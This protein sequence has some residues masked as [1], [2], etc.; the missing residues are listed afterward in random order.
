MGQEIITRLNDGSIDSQMLIGLF[1]MGV[2]GLLMMAAAGIAT[3]AMRKRTAAARHLVWMLALCGL[4]LLPVLTAAMPRWTLPLPPNKMPASTESRVLAEPIAIA[5]VAGSERAQYAPKQVSVN[6]ATANEE[7]T[8]PSS[9]ERIVIER[10]A[11]LPTRIAPLVMGLWIGI[12]T[13]SFSC[14]LTGLQA[15]NQLK[16]ASLP[17]E[18]HGFSQLVESLSVTLGLPRTPAVRL[19]P[20]GSMPMATGLFRPIVYLPGDAVNWS[21]TKLRVVL[22]HEL[23]H[24]K[25][26]DC[27]TYA[28]ARAAVALHWYNPLGWFALRQLR[29]EREHACDDLVLEC[30][31]RPS[32]Y[33]EVLLEIAQTMRTPLGIGAAAVTMA[34]KSHV[35]ARLRA[36]LDGTRNRSLLTRRLIVSSA[37]STASLVVLLSTVAFER[38]TIYPPLH[39]LVYTSGIQVE[40]AAVSSAHPEEVKRE[41]WKPDGGALQERLEGFQQHDWPDLKEGNGANRLVGL[42]IKLPFG[43]PGST[44]VEYIHHQLPYAQMTTD[45]ANGGHGELWAFVDA[46][47][48]KSTTDF[49]LGIATGE[50]STIAQATFGEDVE[51]QSSDMKSKS[52]LVGDPVENKGVKRFYLI[53]PA[54]EDRYRVVGVKPDGKTIIFGESAERLLS[55]EHSSRDFFINGFAPEDFSHLALQMRRCEWRTFHGIAVNPVDPIAATRLSEAAVES[56]RKSQTELGR[57]ANYGSAEIRI[58]PAI[59]ARG[60]QVRW[61]STDTDLGIRTLVP[62]RAGLRPQGEPTE[63]PLLDGVLWSDGDIAAL[64]VVQGPVPEEFALQFQLTSEAGVRWAKTTETSI[65]KQLALVLDGEVIY[66]AT[67]NGGIAGGMMLLTDALDQAEAESLVTTIRAA[68]PEISETVKVSSNSAATLGPEV[69]VTVRHSGENCM[70]DFDTGK[71]FT[72]PDFNGTEDAFAWMTNNGIDAGGGNQPE[73][74]GLIGMDLMVN[75]EANAQWDDAAT[76]GALNH[77]A[78]KFGKPGNPVY[79]SAKGDLPSTWTF[80]T[81]EGG[82]G[83]VQILGFEDEEPRGVK[84]RYRMMEKAQQ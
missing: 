60:L 47:K 45:Y 24:V 41:Y 22:A 70:I 23:A 11:R 75:P 34:R 5:P 80:K 69:E 57:K 15:V 54:K 58:E 50:W 6:V 25:R 67:L 9:S 32:S 46:P 49:D 48:G 78:F 1:D 43:K 13:F 31:E 59:T 65:G 64:E 27:L 51:Y 53:Y 18:S 79:L 37:V 74:R 38:S 16:A 17:F 77:D 36:I 76:N 2:K 62:W 72:P 14:F 42:A 19:G 4:L 68:N 44:P 12:A 21:E 84:I 8:L 28:L 63:L 26:R 40:V 56:G 61:V 20:D 82:L 81:R 33:A 66:A 83:V 52:L 71:L 55:E 39:Q 7:T 3:G 10:E 30:G 29:A 35:E 73:V